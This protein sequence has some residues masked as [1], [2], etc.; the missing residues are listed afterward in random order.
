[1]M[2]FAGGIAMPAAKLIQ[3]IK[4]EREA[5]EIQDILCLHWPLRLYDVPLY[6]AAVGVGFHSVIP[7][8]PTC[9]ATA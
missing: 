3:D 7:D 9:D 1:M 5:C 6:C 8:Y 4:K 2:C